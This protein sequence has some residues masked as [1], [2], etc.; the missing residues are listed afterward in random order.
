MARYPDVTVR[1]VGENGNA[2]FI[3]GKVVRAMRKAGLTQHQ[4]NEYVEE[5]QSGDYDN[6]LR[7]TMKYVNIE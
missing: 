4:I 5:A 7:V 2:F 6:L 1:L 3:L